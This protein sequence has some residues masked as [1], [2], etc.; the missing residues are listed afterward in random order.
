MRRRN[1]V[2]TGPWIRTSGSGRKAGSGTVRK[3]GIAKTIHQTATERKESRAGSVAC[4]GQ[5][6]PEGRPN[7]SG[8]MIQAR[9]SAS[10]S[11]P[12]T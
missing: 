10:R 4:V 12:P 11:P 3:R 9:L 1:A 5:V 7:H 2:F 8:F 6:R